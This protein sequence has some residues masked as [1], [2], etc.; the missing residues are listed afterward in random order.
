METH[1]NFNITFAAFESTSSRPVEMVERK[2]KGHPDT[3][4]DALADELSNIVSRFCVQRFGFILHHNVDKAL[5][6]GGVARAVFGG[7]EVLK[8]IEIFLA[9]RATEEF[10]G[11]NIPIRELVIEGARQWLDRNLHALD[12]ERHV[13]LHCLIRPGSRDLSDLYL[14]GRAA[15]T[16]LAND[17]STGVGYAPLDALE[18][19]VLDVERDLNSAAVKKSHPEIGED[20]KVMGVRR[21]DRI[22]LT[23]ACAMVSRHVR[24]L[25]DYH[26]KKAAVAERAWQTARKISDAPLEV[27]VNGGDGDSPESL[28]LTVTGT[29][30]EAGDDGEVGRGNRA[31][32][33][34]TPYRPMTM[35]APAGKNPVT[36]VGK[37]YNV[38]ATRIAQALVAEIPE[39]Q[40]AYCWLTSQIGRKIDDPQATDVQLRLRDG[41]AL[42]DVESRIS[43]L[44]H[45]HLARLPNLWR[46]LITGSQSVW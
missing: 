29:S 14:R 34:I 18:T 32:G 21:E 20:V 2:G 31:N 30:A 33:L 15:G 17:T 10:E 25:V 8:P 24:S 46:E 9:G 22:T 43:E 44:V 5:L 11:V 39:V 6:C 28:Y 16:P 27:T 37:L 41:A 3:I 12:S 7:G 23:I 36:H 1:M 38:G 13:R 45:N 19:I 26:A 42:H 40:E 35:E 4:C